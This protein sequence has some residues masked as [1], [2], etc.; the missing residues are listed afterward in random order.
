MAKLRNVHQAEVEGFLVVHEAEV[1]RLHSLHSVEI[2]WN[3]AFCEAEKVCLQ[4][5][6]QASYINKLPHLYDK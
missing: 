6:L 3:V 1:E 5:K 2:E 4:S